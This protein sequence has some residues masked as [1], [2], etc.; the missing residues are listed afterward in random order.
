[1][2]GAM[3]PTDRCEQMARQAWQEWLSSLETLDEAW[4]ELA[5][6][7]AGDT[8]LEITT[9]GM[10]LQRGLFMPA[11]LGKLV[12]PLRGGSSESDAPACIERLDNGE[13]A[14]WPQGRFIL[15]R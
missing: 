7:Q 9:G 6:P 1:M 13:S 11:S 10:A 2:I 14:F 8:V 15:V 5:D 3:M 4:R 12:T